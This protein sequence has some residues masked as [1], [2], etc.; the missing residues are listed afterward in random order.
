M[1]NMIARGF[2]Y[3]LKPTPEQTESFRQFAGV[4]RAVYNAALFQRE[5]FWRQYRRN[6]GY[7]IGYVSQAKE[8]TALRAEF[9]WIAAV[10]Q[11][12]EQQ[13]LRDL[14]KAFGN[15]FAGIADYPTPRR[16][17]VNESFRFQ[18]REVE[19]KRLNGGWSAARLPKIGWVRFRDTRPMLGKLKNVTVSLDPLGWH[20]S[21]AREIEHDV[22]PNRGPS[23]G[24]D[25]GVANSI[26]LSTGEL[27]SVPI[28]RLRILD[29]RHRAAQH[30]AAKRRRGSKRHAKSRRRAAAN[31]SHAART[32]KHWNHEATTALTRRFGTV[33]IEA[34]KTKN[35]TASA[36]GTVEE[37]GR[38]VRQKSGLNR[39][40]LEHGWY[41]FES[42]L[43]YKLAASGGTLVK[44]N[45]ANTSR[46]CS[47]CGSIDARNRENQ[48]Q[49][50]CIECG[51][52]AHADCNAA[53]NILRAGTRPS[54]RLSPKRESRRAA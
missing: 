34:L 51:H 27:A 23:V 18:G 15:F 9:D 38:N 10:S 6:T 14:D 1:G 11:T 25:R 13:A 54:P 44:V 39:S 17:C 28:E 43:A 32:R 21:F 52:E 7:H 29:R 45:P 46:T 24:I 31:K 47:Q 12:C 5:H 26:A 42:F 16:R 4:C 30:E 48:A 36:R 40:I 41:Q 19:V 3:K 35:M 2:K 37:P 50:R 20:V 22:A 53:I 8:L 49:F 33:C